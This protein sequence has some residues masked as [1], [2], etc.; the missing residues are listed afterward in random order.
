M[1]TQAK[2]ACLQNAAEEKRAF[3][4]KWAIYTKHLDIVVIRE[5]QQNWAL[6]RGGGENSASRL[7]IALGESLLRHFVQ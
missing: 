2:H 3:L 6:I 4:S 7:L 1:E 5:Q